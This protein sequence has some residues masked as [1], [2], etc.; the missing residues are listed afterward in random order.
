M[1]ANKLMKSNSKNVKQT[2]CITKQIYHSINKTYEECFGMPF[3]EGLTHIKE[4]N[5]ISKPSKHEKQKEKRRL[6]RN[7]KKS[8]EMEKKKTSVKKIGNQ[9][10]QL[11]IIII[12]LVIFL[13]FDLIKSLQSIAY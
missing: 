1:E 7:V 12:S 2:K 3:A 6:V 9:N 10:F 5:I 11:L 13:E 4:C 8:V